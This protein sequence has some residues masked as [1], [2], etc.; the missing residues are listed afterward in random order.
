MLSTTMF[1]ELTATAVAA[2]IARLLWALADPQAKVLRKVE[3]RINRLANQLCYGMDEDGCAAF[4]DSWGNYGSI[5]ANTKPAGAVTSPITNICQTILAEV[6]GGTDGPS[7]GRAEECD[8][9]EESRAEDTDLASGLLSVIHTRSG[10]HAAAKKAAAFCKAEKGVM[11]HNKANELVA[12]RVVR[13]FLTDRGVRP[14]HIAAISP[15][16]VSLV[17]VRTVHEIEARQ[18]LASGPVVARREA[19]DAAYYTNL[20]GEGW[21]G[22]L[23]HRRVVTKPP[24][25]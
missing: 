2:G 8:G 3:P 6:N 17:F 21:L 14:S 23:R 4:E 5:L 10:R 25:A 7:V 13:E 18:L 22:W 19:Y 12:A 15:L 20:P 1:I 11:D 16:A 9:K 24:T